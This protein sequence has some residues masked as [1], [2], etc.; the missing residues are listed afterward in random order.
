MNWYVIIIV[1]ALLV[2]LVIFTIIRNQ[3]DKNEFEQKLNN[4]Y[5]TKK[6]G[7]GDVEIEEEK[8]K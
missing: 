8:L 3:K 2:G 4:D 6:E 5:P 7:E 1:G